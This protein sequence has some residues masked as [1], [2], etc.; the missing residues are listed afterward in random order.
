MNTRMQ[1]RRAME[2]DLRVALG[3]GELVLHYQP[4]LNLETNEISGCEAL[5]RWNHPKLGLVSPADFIPVAEATG[6]I[7]P[8]GEWVL[9]EACREAASWP[10]HLKVAVNL[11][12][13]QFKS[14]NLAQTVVSALAASGLQPSRL[15]LEIT[16]SVLITDSVA[17][18]NI[19]KQLHELGVRIALDDFGTGYSSLSYLHSF[20]FDK[21]KIDR[22][23]VRDIVGRRCQ[24][25][26]DRAHGDAARQHPWHGDDRGR[27]GNHGTARHDPRRRL[28][29][30]AGL[31]VECADRRRGR[32]RTVRPAERTLR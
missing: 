28:H 4:V 9:R 27:R 5:L 26:G 14:R 15:E 1:A 17:T 12:V 13:V 16:E 20:P 7:V 22:C 24:R 18:L 32:A 8:I 2:S 19:L 31:P 10:A 25:P 30:D 6:L 29:G 3:S 11:S 21:I 23:F